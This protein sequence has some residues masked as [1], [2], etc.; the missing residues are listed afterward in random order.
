MVV[1]KLK[2]CARE[3]QAVFETSVTKHGLEYTCTKTP[4][5][6]S[7]ADGAHWCRQLYSAYK[8]DLESKER[9]LQDLEYST[10]KLSQ[11]ITMWEKCPEEIQGM[12]VSST[13]DVLCRDVLFQRSI[14]GYSLIKSLCHYWL[15]VY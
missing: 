2:K 12:Y 1:R 4:E 6:F 10:T 9:S 11:V 8:A 5:A 3:G 14:F 15:G 13:R 7:T